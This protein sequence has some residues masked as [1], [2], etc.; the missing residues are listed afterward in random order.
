[1]REN[2]RQYGHS[3]R[4][5][6]MRPLELGVHDFQVDHDRTCRRLL[7]E[8]RKAVEEDSAEVLILGCTAEYGFYEKMQSELGVPVIDAVLAPFKYAEF[9]AELAQRFGWYP[10]RVWGSEPPPKEEV[11]AWQLF[12]NP[13]AQRGKCRE[14]P[15]LLE[16][17][18]GRGVLRRCDDEPNQRTIDGPAITDAT[19]QRRPGSDRTDGQYALFAR[20]HTTPR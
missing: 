6:S 20:V 1:M 19:S 13:T 9:L 10:S 12:A 4:M 2:V 7:A 17:R 18:V 16:W 14:E 5:V 11:P 3:H 15:P 8:G